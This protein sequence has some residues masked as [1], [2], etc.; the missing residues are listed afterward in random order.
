MIGEAFTTAVSVIAGQ[1]LPQKLHVDHEGVD[2]FA[3]E[4]KDEVCT[5]EPCQLRGPS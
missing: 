3:G 5:V 1:F 4:R 2:F